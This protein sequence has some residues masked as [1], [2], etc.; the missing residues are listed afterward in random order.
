MNEPLGRWSGRARGGMRLEVA[1]PSVRLRAS[2]LDRSPEKTRTIKKRCRVPEFPPKRVP[3]WMS[4]VLEQRRQGLEAYLQGILLYNTELPKELL[5]FLK[6]WHFQQDP[7]ASNSDSLSDFSLHDTSPRFLLSHRPVIRFHRDPY[8][9]P[10]S[11]DLLPEMILSGVLQGFYAP[12]T[13]AC[14]EAA[15][16]ARPGLRLRALPVPDFMSAPLRV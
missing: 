12:E 13:V 9:L 14:L 16:L 10:S 15:F 1:V 3:N 8:L 7:T 11:T 4:K 6:L 2:E 5:E